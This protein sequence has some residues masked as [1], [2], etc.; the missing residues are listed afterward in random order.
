MTPSSNRYCL[1]LAC[2][3][4]EVADG[5]ILGHCIVDAKHLEFHSRLSERKWQNVSPL[6]RWKYV[7]FYSHMSTPRANQDTQNIAC[8]MMMWKMRD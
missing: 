2:K 7:A 4:T 6:Q 5:A 1:L 8:Q 3:K